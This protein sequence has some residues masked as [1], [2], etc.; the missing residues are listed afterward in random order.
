MRPA[1]M[2]IAALLLAGLVT[3]LQSVGRRAN[4]IAA[5]RTAELAAREERFRHAFEAAGIGMALV[6]L[7][8]RWLRVNQSW[9]ESV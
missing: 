7:D 4:A 1:L 9:C 3:S 8:G 5:A 2:M 6:G